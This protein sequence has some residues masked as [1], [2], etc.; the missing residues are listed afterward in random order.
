MYTDAF[1]A[2]IWTV[3]LDIVII[4]AMLASSVAAFYFIWKEM[5][6]RPPRPSSESPTYD[7]EED[8]IKQAEKISREES[9]DLARGSNLYAEYAGKLDFDEWNPNQT[10]APSSALTWM[11]VDERERNHEEYISQEIEGIHC[12]GSTGGTFRLDIQ[13]IQE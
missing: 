2:P 12:D 1:T 10:P 7:N 5:S 3:L 6:E 13:E 8:D 9:V 4:M 11:D